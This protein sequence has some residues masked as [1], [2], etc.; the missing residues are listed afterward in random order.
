MFLLIHPNLADLACCHEPSA[1]PAFHGQCRLLR[2]VV[3][4]AWGAAGGEMK[5][6]DRGSFCGCE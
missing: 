1:P 4:S 2:A 6:I 5:T 3:S